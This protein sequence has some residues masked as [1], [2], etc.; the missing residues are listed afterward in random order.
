VEVSTPIRFTGITKKR[1]AA[2]IKLKTKTVGVLEERSNSKL[3]WF[4]PHFNGGPPNI[5]F[6]SPRN[7][8]T[9]KV[10]RNKKKRGVC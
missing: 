8:H 5:I 7:P 4:K 9:L 2:Y 10:Y 3:N 6:I 1:K